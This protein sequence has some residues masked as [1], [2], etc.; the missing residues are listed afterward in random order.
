VNSTYTG[1]C[2][3]CAEALTLCLC[4]PAWQGNQFSKRGELRTTNITK[5][6]SGPELCS[7][8]SETHS[9]H[10]LVHSPVHQLCC[11]AVWHS[12]TNIR[13]KCDCLI[14]ISPFLTGQKGKLIPADNL[15]RLG[16]LVTHVCTVQSRQ[17]LSVFSEY[18]RPGCNIEHNCECY[19]N[20]I[21]DY[22]TPKCESLNSEFKQFCNKLTN[23]VL[24]N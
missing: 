15:K 9:H 13:D 18:S 20:V 5:C 21:A 11:V 6:T 19:E 1:W 22:C 17:K 8:H 24:V 2:K 7:S 12:P 10:L 4:V 3:D 16:R 23:S 14:L